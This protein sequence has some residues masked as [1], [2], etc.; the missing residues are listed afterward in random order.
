MVDLILSSELSDDDIID[1]ISQLLKDGIGDLDELIEL[2]KLELLI[3]I[4]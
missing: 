4:L 2:L 1:M 3:Q